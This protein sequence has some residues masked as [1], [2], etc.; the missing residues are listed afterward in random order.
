MSALDWVVY[1]IAIASV[2]VVL[3]SLLW[4]LQNRMSHEMSDEY[5]AAYAQTL[6]LLDRQT[7][8]ESHA[9]TEP[10]A[11]RRPMIR[12]LPTAERNRFTDAWQSLQSLFADHPDDAVKEAD[13]LIT[14][15]MQTRGYPIG[16]SAYVAADSSVEQ[17]EIVRHYREA[18]GVAL[19]AADG[20]ATIEE[21]R[22][23]LV[24]YRELFAE[25][26][27]DGP[28]NA[29]PAQPGLHAG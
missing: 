12:P 1:G 24:E 22:H 9:I 7:E 21:E 25:L 14:D 11:D 3:G 15:V 20:Q 13:R 2:V 5:V 4:L 6:R 26:L 10:D 29:S 19:R 28:A 8:A 23:A 16:E 27:G 17:S 18:H